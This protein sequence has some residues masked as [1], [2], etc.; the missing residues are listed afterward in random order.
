MLGI[1]LYLL[2]G[3]FTQFNTICTVDL[4]GDDRDLLLNGF[5]EI[6][7]EFE[8]RFA[9]ASLDDGFRK[10]NCASPSFGPVVADNRG[11]CSSSSGFITYELELGGGIRANKL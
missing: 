6:I 10:I 9:F 1:G 2:L 11:V 5:V 3:E 8:V 4:F 7:Q